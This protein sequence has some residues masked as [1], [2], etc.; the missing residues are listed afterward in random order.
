MRSPLCALIAL[1]LIAVDQVGCESPVHA[2]RTGS[3]PALPAKARPGNTAGLSAAALD[4]A[5]RLYLAKCA[6]CH[7][8]YDPAAYGE[9]EWRAWMARMSRKARLKQD[10]EEL[11]SRYLDALRTRN[12]VD[13]PQTQPKP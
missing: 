10:Q 1:L 3:K 5:G 12:A 7:R 2:R 13:K 11:L 4:Q 9:A 6:R 8:L